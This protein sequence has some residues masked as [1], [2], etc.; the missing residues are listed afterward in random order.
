[1]SLIVISD[2]LGVFANTLTADD[3]YFFRNR[4][5]LPQPIQM[6]LSTKHKFFFNF[7]LDI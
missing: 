6:Q 3:K 4:N 5:N 2:N 1:M 7:L